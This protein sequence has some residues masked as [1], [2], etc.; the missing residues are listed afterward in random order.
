MSDVFDVQKVQNHEPGWE[1]EWKRITEGLL[2]AEGNS[3]FSRLED[4]RL[5]RACRKASRDA[6]DTA[7]FFSD[8]FVRYSEKAQN[9]TLFTS[10]DV[11]QGKNV[12]LFLCSV[13]YLRKYYKEFQRKSRI[14][15]LQ[16]WD[17]ST[18]TEGIC[19]FSMPDPQMLPSDQLAIVREQR[20]ALE[21]LDRDL[22]AL[23]IFCPKTKNRVRQ[24]AGLQLY[25]RLSTSDEEMRKLRGTV[26]EDV[27][28]A[29]ETSSETAEALIRKTHVDVMEILLQK[30]FKKRKKLEERRFRSESQRMNCRKQLNDLEFDRFFSPLQTAEI[31]FLLQVKKWDAM[32]RRNRYLG[33]IQS[34]FRDYFRRFEHITEQ[35]TED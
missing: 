2:T 16:F 12:L 15:A 32:Q 1:K 19:E 11:Q 28:A 20:S 22:H 10:F 5:F 8:M 18:S 30:I 34:I 4:G 24:Q 29:R 13:L 27:R 6:P 25:P 35:K 9:Q 14:A 21:E 7:E 23:V 31:V 33:E 3:D 17:E 26:C